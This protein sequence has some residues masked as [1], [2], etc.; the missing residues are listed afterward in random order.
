MPNDERV[1][2]ASPTS[3][4]VVDSPV[5]L[6][7]YIPQIDL[8][9]ALTGDPDARAAVGRA[10]DK[11]CRTSGF[12]VLS[13][14][15]IDRGLIDRVLD[16]TRR[17]FHVPLEQRRHLVAPPGDVTLRGLRLFH[18]G[19]VSTKGRDGASA[20]GLATGLDSPPDLCELF[21]MNRA[22]EPGVPDTAELAEG[23]AV[24]TRPNRWPDLAGLEDFRPAW[25]EYY[26]E[27]EHLALEVMRFFALGLELDEHYFDGLFDNHLTNLCANYYPPI[28]TPPVDGQFRKFPH[29]DSGT[30]TILYQD[31]EGGLQ[32]V[33]RSTGEWVD[34]PFIENSFVVNIGDLMA[35]WTNN[36]W[37]STHHR[38]LPPP[39]EKWDRERISMPFFHTPNWSAVIE[40]LPSCTDAAT[41][42]AHEPVHSGEYLEYKVVGLTA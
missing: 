35:I 20:D 38:I 18:E 32:V 9:L 5:L 11:A 34:V 29:T 3:A 23:A 30:L 25:L 27:L 41:P 14:H 10:L 12:F 17:F 2:Q 40:C 4:S 1:T 28:T 8:S 39:P 19:R 31:E 24:W 13:G 33:D 16:A 7:G 21:T 6:D 26:G 36:R 22:G 15:G 37:V 42:P